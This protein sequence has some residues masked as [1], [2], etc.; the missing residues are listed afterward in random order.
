E[1]A[2]VAHDDLGRMHVEPEERKERSDHRGAKDHQPVIPP[3]RADEREREEGKDARAAREAVHAIGEVHAVGR[4]DDR[5][6]R[7]DAEHD[8]ADEPFPDERH[9]DAV[10]RE[11]LLDVDRGGD[12][13]DRLPD[14]LVA[15]ADPEAVFDVDEVVDRAE[16]AHADERADGDDRLRDVAVALG[17]R[18]EE[19][20]ERPEKGDDD[21]E[22]RPAH[23]RYALLREVAA[24]TLAPDVLADA[25]PSEEAD[26]R[27]T[28]Y[29]PE[30]E[31]GEH[32]AEREG[33]GRH[34]AFAAGRTSASA[35]S[36]SASECDPFTRTVSPRRR[37]RRRSISA[38]ARSATSC[39][40]R[41]PAFRAELTIVRA[42]SPTPMS[43]SVCRA[44]SRP[45]ASC[46]SA[47][48][49]PS[50]SMSPTTATRRVGTDPST[51]NAAMT[52]AGLAL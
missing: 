33:G 49:D 8:G 32:D 48:R 30:K 4:P 31:R 42:R 24:R 39:V 21:D 34:Q 1:R 20:H 43:T 26:V 11:V 13:H 10:D 45:T 22:E 37:M 17:L 51:A 35:S 50:S 12:R 16:C 29:E 52:A 41:S 44:A 25:E 5:D 15:A 19:P 18:E 2:G 38:S 27:A 28:E 3:G 9:E 47:E 40:S 36:S 14:E 7:D 6:D 23:R 46:A